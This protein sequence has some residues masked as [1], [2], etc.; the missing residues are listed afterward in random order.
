MKLIC[1]ILL[2][3]PINLL[4][5]GYWKI[6]IT[7]KG[8]KKAIIYKVAEASRI[9]TQFSELKKAK[10]RSYAAEF[11]GNVTALEITCVYKGVNLWNNIQIDKNSNIMNQNN[12]QMQIDKDITINIKY[13]KE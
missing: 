3:F 4:A 1:F 6:H 12:H 2:I 11:F 10:C 9:K 8:V 7:H 13:Y 5:A